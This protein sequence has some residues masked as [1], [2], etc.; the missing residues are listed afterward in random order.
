MKIGIV[1]P[2]YF[3]IPPRLYGGTESVI[4]Y[5]VEGLVKKGHEVTL[6]CCE[7]SKTS[8]KQDTTWGKQLIDSGY[9]DKENIFYS[10]A[11]LNDIIHKSD[12]FDLIH[13]HDGLLSLSLSDYFK[14]PL[15]ATFHTSISKSL[16]N[17]STKT[18]EMVFKKSNIISISQAQRKELPDANYIGN[19]Y[20]GTVDFEKYKFGDG[21]DY[22]VWIGRFN[23]Y[24]G[25]KEAIAA[26]KKAKQKIILAAPLKDIAEVE[27]FNQFIQ[28]EINNDDVKYVGEVGVE[29]KNDLLGQ[30]KA[31]LMPISW[32]EPF[33]LVMIESMA[34]GTPVIAFRRGSVEEVINDHGTG[35]I[36]NPDDVDAMAD[37]I[38]N[39]GQIDRKFCREWV[40]NNF[41]I[42]MMVDG[43]E[44]I[45]QQFKK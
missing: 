15:V 5:L 41:S 38:A 4:Y 28:P 3:P 16:G 2:I 6:F 31:F 10:I 11:R 18:R 20:N 17:D 32:E 37:A 35:F 25:A 23:P 43:Y 24:K 30:A 21:G 19:V 13:S 42:E 26:A 34:C 45:Y 29:E 22:L 9:L 1:A 8:A 36:V 33:G 14:C 44:K 40:K 39:I 12:Q 7:G 27:Y